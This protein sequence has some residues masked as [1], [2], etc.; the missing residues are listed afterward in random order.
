MIFYVLNDL[1]ISKKNAECL[2][3][4]IY[5]DSIAMTTPTTD[6][7]IFDILTNLMK[8]KIDISYISEQLLQRNSLAWFRL[9]PKIMNTLDLHAEG[10]LGI[11]HI[12]NDWLLENR[13]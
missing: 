12:E 1:K 10:K 6:I 8:S 4:G 7:K 5:D 11:I 9:L 13:S 2:Y 3:V